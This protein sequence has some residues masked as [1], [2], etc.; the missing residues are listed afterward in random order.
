[1]EYFHTLVAH[2]TYIKNANWSEH[3]T[4]HMAVIHQYNIKLSP[5]QE[6]LQSDYGQ[7]YTVHPIKRVS[8]K[9]NGR[10]IEWF[11]KEWTKDIIQEVPIIQNQLTI[12]RKYNIY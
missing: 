1:M 11:I 2:P 10:H 3:F 5:K 8:Y 4:I 7:S 12:H 9:Q 6:I